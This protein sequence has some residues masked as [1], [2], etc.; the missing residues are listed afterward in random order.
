MRAG[1][2]LPDAG[3]AALTDALGAIRAELAKK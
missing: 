1:V 3:P 2:A